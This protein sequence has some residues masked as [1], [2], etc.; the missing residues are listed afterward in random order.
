VNLLGVLVEV[1]TILSHIDGLG[2]H[3]FD[4]VFVSLTRRKEKD[5]GENIRQNSTNVR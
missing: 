5:L 4:F 3:S 1:F 2:A